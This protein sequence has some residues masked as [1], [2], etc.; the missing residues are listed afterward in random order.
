VGANSFYQGSGAL[1]SQIARNRFRPVGAVVS[2]PAVWYALATAGDGNSRPLVVPSAQGPYNA[3]S[4]L[5]GLQ[6]EGPVGQV[7]GVPWYLDANVPLT[8]GGASTAP[9][10]ST[11]SAGH[12]AAV[13]GTG[14]GNTFTPFLAGVWDDLLLFEG[15]I[16]SRVLQEVL[17][18]TLQVRFQV[19]NYV[20][21]MPNR[22]QDASSRI[23]SYGN[24]NSGTTAGA[25][26][27]TGSGGGLVNF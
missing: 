11:V 5:D 2:N 9:S 7:L 27:S 26:L 8:F 14:T 12:T 4:V 1:L 23:V 16:R 21:F 10:M 22:Y 15:E 3:I 24:A 17:S 19:Y 13:D 20:A 25:A 18:G 6:D